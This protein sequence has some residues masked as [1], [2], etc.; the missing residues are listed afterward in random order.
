MVWIK[1]NGLWLTKENGIKEGVVDEFKVLL[2]VAGG[3]RPSISGLS[4]ARLE[5][6][7]AARLEDLFSKLEV[8]EALKGFSG[9]KLLGL[10]GF[11]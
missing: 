6:V 9:K 10:M 8:F 4:F 7:E 11:L 2:S 1:I 5:I 3:W